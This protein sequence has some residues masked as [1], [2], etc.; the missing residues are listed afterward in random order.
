M[1]PNSPTPTQ[2]RVAI[3]LRT[4]DRDFETAESLVL[5]SPHL[6]ESVG[7]SCQQAVEKYAKAV[8]IANN[9]PAPF[10]HV[11][12]VL[13]QPLVQAAFITIDATEMGSAAVLQDFA[14][15]WR[16]DTDDAPSYTSID[17]MA[18]AQQFRNKLRPLALAFLT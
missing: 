11:L 6:Y 1:Q 13:L 15:E 5:H 4:A 14:V 2:K 18:M 9:L 8:L 17:L 7:F 10:I 12:V 16:Y 3:L